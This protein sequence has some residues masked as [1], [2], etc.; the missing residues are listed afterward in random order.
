MKVNLIIL[1]TVVAGLFASCD[2]NGSNPVSGNEISFL[3][4]SQGQEFSLGVSSDYE[5][6]GW[7]K[8][9]NGVLGTVEEH[10]LMTDNPVKINGL[11][12]IVKVSAGKDHALA[13]SSDGKVYAWGGNENGQ[14]G[15]GKKIDFLY[16][17]FQVEL[18]DNVKIIAAG[19]SYSFAVRHDGSVYSW[20]RNSNGCLG[21][22]TMYESLFP[23]VIFS[24]TNL[25]EF[26]LSGASCMALDKNGKVWTW[27]DN[28]GHKLGREDEAND[29]D[30]LS[31]AQLDIQDKVIRIGSDES[32]F[33]V[34]T[35]RNETIKLGELVDEATND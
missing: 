24:L 25:V 28:E 21:H 19:D 29:Y 16:S 27:G 11:Q 2:N 4:V 9:I 35:D 5:V 33:Y 26:E 30:G 20:G 6:Y 7:G 14:L 10:I 23:K 15:I 17:P 34:V 18:L 22:G 31:P 8:N 3:Q 12:D 32:G 1:L 13:L